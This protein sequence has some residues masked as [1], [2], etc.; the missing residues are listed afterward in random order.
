MKR[1]PL[2]RIFSVKND[3]LSAFFCDFICSCQKKAV[4]LHPLFKKHDPQ[5]SQYV[6]QRSV[7]GLKSVAQYV[8]LY[9]RRARSRASISASESP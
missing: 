8:A 6:N 4:P 1:N 2:L 7:C 9:K 3:P 5:V